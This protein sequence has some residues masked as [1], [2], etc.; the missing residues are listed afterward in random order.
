MKGDQVHRNS[1]GF[2]HIAHVIR[3][4]PYMSGNVCG[5]VSHELLNG[6]DLINPD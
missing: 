6:I 5:G 1:N 2:L 4:E 3:T